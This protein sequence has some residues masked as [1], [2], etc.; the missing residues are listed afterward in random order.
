MEHSKHNELDNVITIKNVSFS[1]GEHTVLKDVSLDVHRG[2]YLTVV[3]ENGSGKT[4]LLKLMLGLLR[5]SRGDVYIF[6]THA[7]RFINDG[8]VGYVPQNATRI[9]PLFPATVHDAV[10]MGL[11]S[12][13]ETATARAASALEKVHLSHKTSAR[14]GSLSG[15][16]LQRVMIARALVNDPEILI[17]DE[18]TVGVSREVRDAFFALLRELNNTH[19][20]TIVLITHDIDHAGAGAMHAAC[21]AGSEICYHRSIP[22]EHHTHTKQREIEHAPQ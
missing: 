10:H 19:N 3:G 8:R 12:H 20:L 21:I 5:P 11:R 18:P 15:G 7:H 22:S 1:Y 17:L 9:D 14:L 13:A 16:E 2:D 6:D 4:T